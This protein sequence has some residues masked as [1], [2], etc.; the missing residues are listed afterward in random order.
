MTI[1]T[2]LAAVIVGKGCQTCTK[3][4]FRGLEISISMDNSCAP[5]YS[6]DLFRTEVR[7]FDNSRGT[8]ISETDVTEEFGGP[9]RDAEGLYEAMRAIA[10]RSA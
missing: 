3:V 5:A 7:I 8:S 4:E 6:R 9:W 1:Y 2:P 10:A